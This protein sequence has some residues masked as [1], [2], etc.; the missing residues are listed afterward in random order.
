M[1]EAK[2]TK[3][4][5]KAVENQIGGWTV[6]CKGKSDD[7]DEYSPTVCDMWDVTYGACENKH[8]EPNA[9]LIAAA[10]EMYDLLESVSKE[11]SFLINEANN[12]RKSQ[13][14]SATENEPD[15]HD[16]ETLYLIGKLLAK[17]RGEL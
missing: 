16:H 3:G 12:Q 6:N 10:P 5:W 11:L 2:F 17:A 13:I 15:Y 9:H 14:T 4:P 8:Q 7:I 1:I